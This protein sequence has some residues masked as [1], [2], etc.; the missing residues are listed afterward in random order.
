[1]LRVTQLV[2]Q[3][4]EP[5]MA[6]RLHDLEHHGVV[7][8]VHIS[9]GDMSR[10]RQQVT[11]DRGTELALL[12]DRDAV[13]QNGSVLWLEAGRAVV[14]A[15]DA[16]QW[17]VLRTGHA[18]RALELGYFAGNMHWKVRFEGEALCIAMEGPR[19]GYLD[20]MAHLLHQGDVIV[21]PAP[22]HETPEHGHSHAH[23]HG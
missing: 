8:T 1:M 23:A 4:C 6:D 3:A 15:L 11:S 2:G 7:E 20:R 9:R 22:D 16:P 12:L 18:A 17:L 10:R 14:V 21:D 19:S 13:L 5:A